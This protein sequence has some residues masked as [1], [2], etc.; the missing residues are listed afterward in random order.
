MREISNCQSGGLVMNNPLLLNCH[1]YI[2]DLNFEKYW[3]DMRVEGK[4]L[5]EWLVADN[6][7]AWNLIKNLDSWEAE[8]CNYMLTFCRRRS[9]FGEGHLR[10]AL[11]DALSKQSK[12]A[13]QMFI[14]GKV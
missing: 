7:E 6:Q 14:R 2:C 1:A 11:H 5:V 4:S 9:P 13:V 3:D 12:R 10:R 8:R